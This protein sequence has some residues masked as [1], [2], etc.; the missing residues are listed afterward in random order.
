M[1]AFQGA[2]KGL[3]AMPFDEDSISEDE[4]SL[5]EATAAK[6]IWG[7][8][9]QFFDSSDEEEVRAKLSRQKI[10]GKKRIDLRPKVQ[11]QGKKTPCI[12]G[13]TL[14]LRKLSA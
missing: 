4:H 8:G 2:N 7:R 6:E 1:T 11:R 13:R 10:E 3:S 12:Q 5:V 14:A 9:D